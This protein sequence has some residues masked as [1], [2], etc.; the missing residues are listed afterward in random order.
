MTAPDDRKV[1]DFLSIETRMEGRRIIAKARGQLGPVL[2]PFVDRFVGV[3]NSLKVIATLD[4]ANM[5]NL[6]NPPQPSKAGLR[7]LERKLKEVVFGTVF[8]ATANFAVTFKCQCRCVHCSADPFIDPN[9]EELSTEELLTAI[10]GALDL[11]ASLVIFTGGEPML[12]SDLYDLVA[13]VDHDR[14][15]PMM[16]TNGQFLTEENVARLKE[17]GLMT[18]NI[19]IDSGDAETHN[20]LRQ[21]PNLFQQA[22]AGGKRA[23]EAGILVGLSTYASTQSLKTGSL[24]HL[25]K[26]AQDEGF[27]EV[28][29]FDCIPSGKW[30]K[31]FEMVLTPDERRQVI[32]LA[33]KYH[34]MKHPMGVVAQSKVNSPEGAGCFGAYSQFYLTA[35]GDIN[36]CDFN[37][38]SFGNVR[39]LPIQLL[40][41]KMVSH[42]DFKVHHKTCR[43]QTPAYR[44]KYVDWLADDV[45]LPVPIEDIDA[46]GRALESSGNL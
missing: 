20:Q 5:Y 33:E 46:H 43:M 19:S 11:G 42:P 28:T 38:I 26:F 22:I 25:L 41:Q 24:E 32:E 39:D 14:A 35:Y 2:R 8:P 37:P 3:L 16:F 44:A 21:V 31:H 4:G 18:M 15:M 36:P 17:A 9:R 12:R 34:Q 40:W 45:H 1:F 7:A 23:L 30:L 27:N 13:H 10:D 29:I 6:Y